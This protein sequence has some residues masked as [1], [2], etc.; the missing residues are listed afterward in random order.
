MDSLTL[1]ATEETFDSPEHL[2]S[3][4][5]KEK[6]DNKFNGI[7]PQVLTSLLNNTCLSDLHEILASKAQSLT[8]F[9]TLY[10]HHPSNSINYHQL[11]N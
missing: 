9:T 10:D 3:E 4:T 5:E 8:S 1:G 7:K 11:H 6:L 2:L